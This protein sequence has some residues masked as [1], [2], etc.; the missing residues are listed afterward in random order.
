MILRPKKGDKK[1]EKENGPRPSTR[2]TMDHA[3]LFVLGWETN[4]LMTHEIKRDKRED[5][6]KT[7]DELAYDGVRI[8]ITLRKVATFLGSDGSLV[9]Q[10]A[11]KEGLMAT[12]PSMNALKEEDMLLKAFS[13]ENRTSDYHWDE[14][15]GNGFSVVNFHMTNQSAASEGHAE[16]TASEPEKRVYQKDQSTMLH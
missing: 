5:K 10:G 9:G 12:R 4:K 1:K 14:L 3:S 15:Y 6:F 7:K 11:P 13:V 16:T 8:S 2:V